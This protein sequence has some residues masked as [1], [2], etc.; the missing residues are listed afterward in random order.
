MGRLNT[1]RLMR[2]CRAIKRKQEEKEMNAE[3]IM[4]WED[5]AEQKEMQ[6]EELEHLLTQILNLTKEAK[7]RVE[8]LTKEEAFPNEAIQDLL[9]AA[10]FCPSQVD[11]EA[12][13]KDMTRL[14]RQRRTAKIQLEV[15]QKFQEWT[16]K[17]QPALNALTQTLGAMRRILKRQPNDFYMWKTDV[18]GRPVTPLIKDEDCPL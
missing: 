4:K 5:I 10:E 11:P 14:R 8:E 1:K 6:A 13:L 15:F 9:H 17:S 18:V 2:Q 12:F 7:R 3:E 16:D